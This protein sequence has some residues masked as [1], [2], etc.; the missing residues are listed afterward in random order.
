MRMDRWTVEWQCLKIEKER[1]EKEEIEWKTEHD[2][3]HLNCVCECESVR[4]LEIG[5]VIIGI[6]TLNW[7]CFHESSKRHG[8]M[9]DVIIVQISLGNFFSM[10]MRACVRVCAD[11]VDLL[12]YAF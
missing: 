9:P 7:N 1:K 12:C 2:V 6:L 10:C 4:V 3:E 8:R 5:I 11:I